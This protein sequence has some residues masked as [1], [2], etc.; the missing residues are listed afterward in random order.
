MKYELASFRVDRTDFLKGN[1]SY[2]DYP[3]GGFLSTTVG[4]NAFS[5]PGLLTQAP[6]LG[7][8]VTASLPQG[9]VASFA[10][11]YGA[12]APVVFATMITGSS[13]GMWFTA[14]AS[15]GALTQVGSYDNTVGRTYAIG[16]TDTV[17]YN[18][19]MYT[20]TT[21]DIVEQNVDGTGQLLTWWTV[22]KGKAAL[23]AGVPHPMLVYESILYIADGKYLHKVDGTT[24][25]VQV[26]DCPPN[27][28]ITAMTEYNGLIYLVAEPYLNSTGVIHGGA[29][30]FS[31][32]GT[33]ESWFEQYF[34]NYRVNAMYV[35]KNRLFMWTNKFMGQWD[36]AKLVPLKSVSNQ[37]LKCHITETSDSMLYADGT[38]I[39]RFG[40]PF[41]PG[42][43]EKFFSYLN[44]GLG[45]N[46]SGIISVQNNNLIAVELA[47]GA[48]ESKNYYVSDINTPTTTGNRTFVFNARFFNKPVKVRRLVVEM[49]TLVSS[50]SNYIYPTFI[51]DRGSTITPTYASG[52]IDGAV[53]TQIGRTTF[54]F[55]FNNI[56]DTRSIQPRLQMNGNSH[57]R[58]I[59][60][61]Y[62]SSEKSLNKN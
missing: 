7:N 45:N 54:E 42:A 39:V 29:I 11:G 46:W 38:N 18:A 51:N 24:A 4:A 37:V 57:I 26:F 53:A 55:E 8:S 30:M 5:K 1:N 17:F 2:V 22:T 56:R 28:V 60:Y 21:D 19:K 12:S 62:E 50:A 25:T 3:D 32:D 43:T 15:T 14:N 40:T 9:G 31:W 33:T 44:S 20:S 41:F 48:S 27:Y 23:T 47:N 35:Y 16:T 6:A 34:I 49:E 36:G 59:D 52:T 61:F 58:S 13:Q 10:L